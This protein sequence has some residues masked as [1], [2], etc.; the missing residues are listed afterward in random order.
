VS[1]NNG[2]DTVTLAALKAERAKQF[3][4]GHKIEWFDGRLSSTLALYE[5]TKRNRGGSVP[6]AEPPFYNTVTIGEARSRGLEW[7]LSGQ[8]SKQLSLIASYAYT[9]TEVLVDPTYQ[10]KQLANVA[11][12]AGSVWAR[13][14]INSQWSTAAGVFAQGQ[15]QGDSGNTFQM[16]G[17]A[18]VD[19]MLGYRFGWAGA[20]A[21]LQFNLDNVFDR[22]YYSGSHQF[23]QDWIKLGAPRTAKATLRLDY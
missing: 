13:Y 17:Y 10:G 20:K 6:V 1:A 21:S 18:R 7:D 22:K 8:L 2:R 4:I 23:V 15:R 12:H 11:R 5:L 14:E 3:E 19:A 16:P 9:D